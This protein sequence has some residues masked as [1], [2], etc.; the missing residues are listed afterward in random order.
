MASAA[1]V[2]PMS[3][4]GSKVTDGI[5]PLESHS[6]GSGFGTRLVHVGSEPDEQTGAVIPTISLSTTFKQK[7][8]GVY[9]GGYDYSRSDNPNRHALEA[10]L[11]SIESGGDRALTFAS[12]SAATASLLQ[13][14]GPGA[15]IISVNDVYGGTFRYMK[16]VAEEVQGLSVTFMDLEKAE[17][18]GILSALRPDTKLIW[19][20]SPTNPTLRLIDIP[21]LA[22]VA[23]SHP[24]QPLI[25]VDNTFL[26]P[27]YSSPLRNGADIVL[28]SMTK[29][30]NGHSD[31]VMGTLIFP[32]TSAPPSINDA[33]T[34]ISRKQRISALFDRVRFIQNSFGAV[35]SPH[36][37]WLLQ[38]GSKTLHLRMKQHGLS[39]LALARALESSPHVQEVIY[40]GLKNHPRYALARSVVMSSEGARQW[41]EE[42]L[43]GV[44]KVER[45][46]GGVPFSGMV[47]FR[48]RSV[49]PGGDGALEAERFLQ[50][51]QIFALAESLG[52]VESLAE[53]PA[54]MTHKSI[55]QEARDALGIGASLIRLSVGIEETKDLIE[56]VH[57]ALDWAVGGLK[58]NDEESE[59]SEESSLK[60]S[61]SSTSIESLVQEQEKKSA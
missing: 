29:Y 15:H 9:K 10:L 45:E 30:I 7:A 38:R 24:S 20:E 40:P 31:V 21:R 37:A 46:R 60:S 47:S 51:V 56:D 53:A 34:D 33:A 48:I 26:S 44:D 17:D 11:A 4:A 36:D 57:Q 52:G 3:F 2:S 12:G 14:L 61:E 13:S 27:F 39:A 58:E 42:E 49:V 25:L 22:R 23:R 32:S 1:D 43:G 59:S 18:E 55:P 6:V 54:E 35:P 28:H 16:R 5:R 8:P 41:I 19:V 50:R